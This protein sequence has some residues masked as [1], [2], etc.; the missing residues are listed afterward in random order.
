M[1]DTAEDI[2]LWTIRAWLRQCRRSTSSATP[3]NTALSCKPSTAASSL[4][5]RFW[6]VPGV[7]QP[8]LMSSFTS[9]LPRKGEH[10]SMHRSRHISTPASEQQIQHNGRPAATVDHREESVWLYNERPYMTWS[11]HG[12]IWSRVRGRIGKRSGGVLESYDTNRTSGGG[13]ENAQRIESPHTAIIKHSRNATPHSGNTL[14]CIL[15]SGNLVPISGK[16]QP[17]LQ[18][19]YRAGQLLRTSSN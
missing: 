8:I 9:R 12:F 15:G 5:Y 7:R 4:P 10:A 6:S 18:R 14:M 11:P 3:S 1:V 2:K 13:Q 19:F 17:C 16:R